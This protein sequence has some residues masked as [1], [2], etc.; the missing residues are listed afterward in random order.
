MNTIVQDISKLKLP[1]EVEKLIN[2]YLYIDWDN[3]PVDGKYNSIRFYSYVDEWEAEEIW[4]KK[5]GYRI[6]VDNYVQ[7]VASVPAYSDIYDGTMK[8]SDKEL[9]H[10]NECALNSSFT[11]DMAY[12]L[13][14]FLKWRPLEKISFEDK[15][16]DY[17]IKEEALQGA[18]YVQIVCYVLGYSD[19]EYYQ[20]L[21]K[22]VNDYYAYSTRNVTKQ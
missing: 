22:R 11:M 9:N 3:K 16:W 7:D 19:N 14:D 21:D 12:M 20:Y 15:G 1:K 8:M 17:L 2:S 10:F 13:F 18:G 6:D 4:F 5:F